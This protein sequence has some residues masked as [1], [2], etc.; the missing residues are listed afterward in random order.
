M[1]RI[2]LSTLI[3]VGLLAAIL[4][5]SEAARPSTDYPLVCRG[6]KNLE[7]GIAPGEGNIGFKFTRGTK[8]AGQGLEPGQCS[9]T[10]R[11]MYDA[12][13]NRVSQHVEEVV[14][15][16]KPGWYEDLHSS[17]KYW[18]FMVSNNG[19]G[20]LIATSA[21]PNAEMN[22]LPLAS[23]PTRI[24]EIITARKPLLPVDQ[25]KE[26]IR[27]HQALLSHIS[28]RVRPKLGGVAG[29]A[30]VASGVAD[31]VSQS[32]GLLAPAISVKDMKSPEVFDN[33]EYQT[34]FRDQAGR[35][36][37]T[38][39]AAIAALEAAYKRAGYPSDIDLSEQYFCWIRGV[40]GVNDP[41]TSPLLGTTRAESRDDILGSVSGGGVSYNFMLL[42]HYSVPPETFLPYVGTSDYD[43]Y[44]K[45][46]SYAKY[47]LTSYRWDD[48]NVLQNSINSWNFDLDQ[49]NFE[50]RGGARY[51]VAE[52]AVLSR[53]QVSD[54]ATLEF[55]IASGRDVAIGTPVWGDVWAPDPAKP[56]WKRNP[57]LKDPVGGHA[58]LL[59][60]YDRKRQFFIAKNSWGAVTYDESKLAD[61][62]KDVAKKYQGYTLVD[63]GYVKEFTDGAYI[64]KVS[65][66]TESK[67]NLQ[68]VFGQW[69]C[70]FLDKSSG[71][72][73]LK[74]TLTWRHLPGSF[75]T[76]FGRPDLRV[77][78]FTDDTGRI[79]RV[80][81]EVAADNKSVTLY[82]D[83]SD[84][85]LGYTEE[86]GVVVECKLILVPGNPR[87]ERTAL[88]AGT[89]RPGFGLPKSDFG[90][91]LPPAFMNFTAR[92]R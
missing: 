13:P 42:T 20:Q 63:Y 66:I 22:L 15:A 24:G 11:A 39:F 54:A 90:L 59:V 73:L 33:L 86:R 31:R 7:I 30:K 64:T 41:P 78:D 32:V 28:G 45:W 19:A 9:W 38:Y 76:L 14:G 36:T 29:G 83:L 65:D 27:L 6:G 55:L 82:M 68:R 5:G 69:D 40:S 34:G 4:S 25:M 53:A 44:K 3:A 80:N 2:L 21:R 1:K 77:G 72:V 23:V 17:D 52:Y 56:C 35:G 79:T 85:G 70:E 91:P 8:P 50:A 58:I 88:S 74:G 84:G 89:I 51:G 61:D 62:W 60:G 26:G 47:D 71:K 16:P 49:N 12:E 18:T 48:P 81:G 92:L 75:D 37:C 57:E 46:P 43:N 87:L 67:H 10:D